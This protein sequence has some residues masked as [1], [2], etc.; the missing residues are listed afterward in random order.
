VDGRELEVA[1]VMK[2]PANAIPGQD[3]NRI[4]MPFFTMHKMYPAS[5]EML[6]MAQTKHGELPEARFKGIFDSHSLG[7]GGAVVLE[8]GRVT[9]F[10]CHL[11]LSKEFGKI[12]NMGTR[13]TAALGLSEKTDALCLAVSQEHGTISVSRAGEIQQV[14][15]LQTL[16]QL[17]EDFLN[18][19]APLDQRRTALHFFR[20]NVKEKAIAVALAV[21]LWLIFIGFP[22]GPR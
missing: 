16:Q 2:R 5:Q 11:P 3:D 17:V 18:E 4:L 10:G 15:N 20:Y 22:G 9:R 13:H 6:L 21:L 19:V 14:T 12:T 1:G 7:H 8:Q